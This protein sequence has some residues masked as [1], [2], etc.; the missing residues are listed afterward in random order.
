ML[1]LEGFK[2]VRLLVTMLPEVLN[3]RSD[4]LLDAQVHKNFLAISAK[5]GYIS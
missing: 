4:A 5:T 2:H 1:I 3:V